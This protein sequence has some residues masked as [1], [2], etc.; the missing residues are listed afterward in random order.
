MSDDSSGREDAAG[1]P[2]QGRGTMLPPGPRGDH[3]HRHACR[4]VRRASTSE[5]EPCR[6]SRHA[7]HV[8]ET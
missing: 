7:Y 5:I 8:T 2:L 4:V 1:S 6:L 3:T